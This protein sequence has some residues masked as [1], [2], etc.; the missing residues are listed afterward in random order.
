MVL[1]SE[2]NPLH[3]SIFENAAPLVRINTLRIKYFRE[4]NATPPLNPCKGVRPKVYKCGKAI[5]QRMQ[6]PGSGHDANGFCH[7]IIALLYQDCP[8]ST[9][10]PCKQDGGKKDNTTIFHT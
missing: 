1:C 2:D 6:L 9:Q 7:Y 3:A 8:G 5:V 10:T 4:L